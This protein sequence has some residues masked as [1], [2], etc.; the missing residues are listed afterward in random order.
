MHGV[1]R[2]R[3]TVKLNRRAVLHS[4]IRQKEAV[5]K[6]YHDTL[7]AVEQIHIQIWPLKPLRIEMS[8]PLHLASLRQQSLHEL[9]GEPCVL[10]WNVH[11]YLSTPFACAR[12]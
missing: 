10:H 9:L 7:Y 6:L 2:T 5:P 8:S 12:S 1:C 3:S 4:K 11:I